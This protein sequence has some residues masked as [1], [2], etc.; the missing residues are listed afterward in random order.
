MGNLVLALDS[1][2]F[3]SAVVERSIKSKYLNWYVSL[4]SA[5]L[6]RTLDFTNHTDKKKHIGTTLGSVEGHHILPRCLCSSEQLK[7][8]DNICYLTAREHFVAHLLLCKLFSGTTKHKMQFA[9]SRFYQNANGQVRKLTSLEYS[10]LRSEY[11]KA[12]SYDS[13]NMPEST[14]DKIS[15]TVK[16]RYAEGSYDKFERTS[17][18]LNAS[19]RNINAAR[20]CEAYKEPRIA[21][22]RDSLKGKRGSSSRGYKGLYV[23]PFGSFESSCLAAEAIGVTANTIVNMC[24]KRNLLPLGTTKKVTKYWPNAQ[25]GKTP[26]EQGWYFVNKDIEVIK[27]G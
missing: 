2:Y 10:L 24:V 8:K 9:I 22:I 4:V 11:A 20:S 7:D 15:N 18:F 1:T 5:A 25:I 17:K 26:F 13:L 19:I 16:Q 6:I 14:R 3:I 27:N 12:R 23:T 21:K